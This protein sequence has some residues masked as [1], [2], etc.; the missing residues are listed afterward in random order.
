MAGYPRK[1]TRQNLGPTYRDA[2]KPTN[3]ESEFSAGTLNLM[4]WQ[5]AGMN[6]PSARAFFYVTISGTV[7]TTA[8]Q[9]MAWDPNQSLSAM[10][11]VRTGAGVYTWSLPN[12]GLGVGIYPDA[13]GSSV[14]AG[15]LAAL[16]S[17][18]GT[19]NLNLVSDV[20]LDGVSGTVNVYN[21][22]TGA[23]AD[24]AAFCLWAI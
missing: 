11:W 19:T 7:L 4:A 23:A 14:S 13:D 15:L 16:G 24:P 8:N 1:I 9:W 20:N 12:G 5:L 2:V 17:V 22:S 18:Q 10:A 21:A 3:P 6:G